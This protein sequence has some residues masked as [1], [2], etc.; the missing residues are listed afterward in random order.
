[1][2]QFGKTVRIRLS[3]AKEIDA[4][5]EYIMQQDDGE[6]MIIFKTNKE[7]EELISYRKISIDVIWWSYEGLKVPN[8]ALVKEDKLYYIIRNR[9]DY[10]DKIPVNVLKQN[11]NYAIIDNYKTSELK[12]LGINSETVKTISLYDEIVANP[13]K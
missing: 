8:S 13:K 9:T 1:M 2:P 3:N 10:K 5:V 4:D 6:V 11:R 12:E 7:V